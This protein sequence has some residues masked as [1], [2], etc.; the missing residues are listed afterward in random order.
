[1]ERTSNRLVNSITA[2]KSRLNSHLFKSSNCSHSGVLIFELSL[3]NSDLS[4]YYYLVILG[5]FLNY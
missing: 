2:L 4:A 3:L 1:M 5:V